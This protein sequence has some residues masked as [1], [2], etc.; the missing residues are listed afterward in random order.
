[1]TDLKGKIAVVTGANSG[2]G[3]EIAK[4]LVEAGMKVVGC[5][6]NE[7][8]LKA[9]AEKLNKKGPGRMFARRCDVSNE[10][11]VTKL[12]KFVRDKF[13]TL[14]VMVNNAG[15]AHNAPLLTGDVKEWRSM[16]EVNVLG[17]CMCT[18]QACH[19]MK[20]ANMKQ[21]NGHVIMIN[22]VAGHEVNS[23]AAFYSSTKFAVT[24]LTEGLR[25]ELRAE[26]SRIRVTSISPGIIKTPF[27]SKFLKADEKTAEERINQ[28]GWLK[29]EDVAA[30]VLYALK[31]PLQMDVHDVIIKPNN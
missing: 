4:K 22:S 21:D 24:A 18:Q 1:M 12:F 7:E 2:L 16:Y 6:R 20:S 15:L 8:K 11:D 31:T 3:E 27:I 17:L 26:K 30:S 14:H 5:S 13:T 23:A 25:Q 29:A 10:D 28:M 9:V 19:L